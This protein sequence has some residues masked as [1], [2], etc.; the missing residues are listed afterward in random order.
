MPAPNFR[1]GKCR[2]WARKTQSW[3]ST[4]RTFA[5]LG[6]ARF[7]PPARGDSSITRASQLA[8]EPSAG[9][10]RSA[11]II[12][13]R[14]RAAAASRLNVTH[15]LYFILKNYNL[16]SHERRCTPITGQAAKIR[17]DDG[18]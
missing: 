16:L 12:R 4:L 17:G 2:N 5:A 8:I 9:G 10:P 15:S 13:K 6:L 14:R 3:P 11:S 7:R 1:E 18:N